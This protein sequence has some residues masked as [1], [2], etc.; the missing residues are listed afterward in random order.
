MMNYTIGD[1]L[2]RLKNAYMAH[3]RSVRHPYSKMRQAL[4]D[5]LV[6]EGYLKST[7]TLEEDGK[8][9]LI[10]VLLYKDH[11]ATIRDV[12]LI[13]KPSVH[14]YVKKSGVKKALRDFGTSIV[15]TSQGMMSGKKANSL[16][17]GGELIAK[18]LK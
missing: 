17:I 3:M 14:H 7:E 2:I 8:K 9:Y 6:E 18:I 11:K 10:T 16:A 5:I 4:A 12:K 13:S 15:S 1:F